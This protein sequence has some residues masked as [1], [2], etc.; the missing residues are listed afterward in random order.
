MAMMIVVTFFMYASVCVDGFVVTTTKTSSASSSSSAASQQPTATGRR[1]NQ[2]PPPQSLPPLLLLMTDRSDM[3]SESPS[4]EQQQQ[5]HDQDRDRDRVVA[6]VGRTI[7][8]DGLDPIRAVIWSLYN[9]G[10]NIVFPTFAVLMMMKLALQI[11]GYGVLYY[12]D[13]MHSV[14]PVIQMDTVQHLQLL[15]S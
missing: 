15:T 4:S 6:E 7:R 10:Q 13:E 2:A 14:V 5:Q 12:W 3:A 11:S 1:S 8:G 9:V